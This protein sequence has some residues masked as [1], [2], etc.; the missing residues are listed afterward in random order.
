ML[1]CFEDELG[2]R[3]KFGGLMGSERS[4]DDS[5]GG[6]IGPKERRSC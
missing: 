2:G 5:L 4:S 6:E 3:G 1:V